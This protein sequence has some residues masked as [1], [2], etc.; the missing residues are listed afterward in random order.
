MQF[1]TDCDRRSLGEALR[2]WLRKAAD[3][4]GWWIKNR[5]QRF[6]AVETDWY[7]HV[8]VYKHRRNAE[9]F[10]AEY[11]AMGGTGVRVRDLG[12]RHGTTWLE[13]MDDNIE[14]RAAEEF[15]YRGGW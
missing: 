5:P 6:H 11:T 1:V 10:V 2:G 15:G 7:P 8:I 13:A 3:D 9:R 4:V 14:G 12:W